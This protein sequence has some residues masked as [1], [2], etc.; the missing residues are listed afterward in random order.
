MICAPLNRLDED[1]A[2]TQAAMAEASRIVL[3]SFE[4]RTDVNVIRYP[5]RYMDPRGVV[6]WEKVRGLIDAIELARVA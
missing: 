3:K 4:L 2:R 6:M 1:I 5:D